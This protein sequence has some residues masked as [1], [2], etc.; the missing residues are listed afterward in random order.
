MRLL[1]PPLLLTLIIALPAGATVLAVDGWTEGVEVAVQVDACPGSCAA[2]VLTPPAYPFTV[3]HVYAIAGPEDQTV[4]FDVR[5]LDVGTQLYPDT[6][7]LLGGAEGVEREVGG[8]E[9]SWIEVDLAAE[10]TPA[11]IQSGRFAVA[12]CFAA[13][14]DPCGAWGLAVDPGPAMTDGGLR[15]ILP[16]EACNGGSCLGGTG[17]YA[18]ST[19][20]ASGVDANWIIRVADEAW[21]PSAGDDDDSAAP[22]DDDT[23]DDDDDTASDDDTAGDDD[24]TA[25]GAVRVD[26]IDP[27]T[28]HEGDVLE[29]VVTGDGFDEDADLLLGDLRVMP[30]DVDD[31]VT[32]SGMFPSG[33]DVGLHDV[34]VVNPDS[35]V[36]C[37]E[38]GLEVIAVDDC[39]GCATTPAPTGVTLVT[40]LAALAALAWRRRF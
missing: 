27:A 19:L 2:V 32:V 28:V 9:W 25:D 16:G 13:D 23:G 35:D 18:W 20:A 1:G 7:A 37:L 21:D 12:L 33:L 4:R 11:E 24:S 30:V 15:W 10:G 40:A 5:V 31:G 26:T 36:D 38:L 29:F 17:E 39:G 34:C 14:S 8:T 3:E 22:T 6:A